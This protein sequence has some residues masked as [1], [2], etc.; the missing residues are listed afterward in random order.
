MTLI[1]EETPADYDAV[2]EL[3]RRVFTGD[4]EAQ[5]VDRLRADAEAVASLVAIENGEIGGHILFSN[6]PIETA[7]GVIDAVS[8]APMSVIPTFQRRGIGS[9][10]V[11]EGLELCR[12]RG[13]SIVVVLGHPQY[14]PRFG[15]SAELAKALRGPYSGDAWMALELIPGALDG[16]QGTVRYPKAFDV[17]S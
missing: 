9:A 4:G 15:F 12:A 2:R 14:Y 8:L 1:R 6:L 16:I 13:R 11:R 10:L 17:L 3:N 7:H 5:L